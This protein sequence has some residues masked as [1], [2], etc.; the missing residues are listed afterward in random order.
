[1]THCLKTKVT[2]DWHS[3]EVELV[4]GLNGT[5]AF[6]GERLGEGDDPL[7]GTLHSSFAKSSIKCCCCLQMR[8]NFSTHQKLLL[9]L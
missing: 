7:K 6:K 8:I 1:M 2:L 5:V 4:T 3:A 9:L